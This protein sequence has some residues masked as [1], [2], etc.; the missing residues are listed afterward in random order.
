MKATVNQIGEILGKPF[1]GHPS[2]DVDADIKNIKK[3]IMILALKID[4]LTDFGNH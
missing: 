2:R 4:L 1:H 3:A